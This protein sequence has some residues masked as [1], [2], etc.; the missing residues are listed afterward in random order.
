VRWLAALILLAPAAAADDVGALLERLARGT[1]SE[2]ARTVRT[3]AARGP[4]VL[5]RLKPVLL[6]NDGLRAAAAADVVAALGERG[7]PALPWLLDLAVERRGDACVAAVVAITA[8]GPDAREALATVEWLRENERI[9]LAV[10]DRATL[11]LRCDDTN[12]LRIWLADP[13]AARARLLHLAEARERAA[14]A[15]AALVRS[16]SRVVR[17]AVLSYLRYED[18]YPEFWIRLLIERAESEEVP[19][20]RRAAVGRLIGHATEAARPL[21]RRWLGSGDAERRCAGCAILG[22]LPRRDPDEAA[23]REAL[24]DGAPRV[25]GYAAAAL[26]RW[27]V[28][29][30]TLVPAL[31]SFARIEDA[32]TKLQG[33]LLLLHLG[34]R[35]AWAL[36]A[37]SRA[38]VAIQWI[39]RA[40]RFQRRNLRAGGGAAG[41]P[42]PGRDDADDILLAIGEAAVP[43]VAAVDGVPERRRIAFLRRFGAPARPEVER[44]LD[45]DEW[46]L[47]TLVLIDL[48]ARDARVLASLAR[49]YHEVRRDQV[50]TTMPLENAVETVG[51]AHAGSLIAEFR[52]LDWDRPACRFGFDEFASALAEL[53]PAV[54]ELLGKPREDDLALAVRERLDRR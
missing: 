53:G 10:A 50:A 35:D 19:R 48:G 21:A 2:R 14:P 54:L 32:G 49:A 46:V 25:R 27:K 52:K 15:A 41:V 8:L 26:R 33:A 29:D 24:R 13:Q 6:G 47:A 18:Q 12:F 44:R 31:R 36:R 3:L 51:L 9:P 28:R 17:R 43:H 23:V 7:L 42:A 40:F 20:L 34:V 1:S 30:E 45:G 5:P 22:R 38:A 39:P 37:A 4:A 16:P 11:A